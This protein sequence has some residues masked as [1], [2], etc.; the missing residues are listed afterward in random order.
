MNARKGQLKFII[1]FELDSDSIDSEELEIVA[2]VLAELLSD[3][4]ELLR[5]GKE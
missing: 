5:Q 3:T 2:R 1:D 4:E